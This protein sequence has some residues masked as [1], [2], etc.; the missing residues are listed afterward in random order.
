MLTLKV[1]NKFLNF[2]SD[3][4]ACLLGFKIQMRNKDKV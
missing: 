3:P 1:L 4:N 2:N